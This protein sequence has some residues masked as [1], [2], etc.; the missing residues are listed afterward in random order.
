MANRALFCGSFIRN[1]FLYFKIL[2]SKEKIFTDGRV[3]FGKIDDRY[4]HT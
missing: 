2:M 3:S 4:M 1:L